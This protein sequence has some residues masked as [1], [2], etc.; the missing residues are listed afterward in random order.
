MGSVLKFSMVKNNRGWGLIIVGV[1]LLLAAAY[2]E[3]VFMPMAMVGVTMPGGS[4]VMVEG[5]K[6]VSAILF[7]A[8]ALCVIAGLIILIR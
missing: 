2:Y 8:G 1:I 5:I 3:A 6:P 7:G 4:G